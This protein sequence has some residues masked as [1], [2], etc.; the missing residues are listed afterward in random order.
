MDLGI[1]ANFVA[2]IS[3]PCRNLAEIIIS[4]SL[5]QFGYIKTCVCEL[6]AFQQRIIYMGETLCEGPAL[7]TEI[8]DLALRGVPCVS[9][10][11]RGF[12]RQHYNG[13]MH[14]ATQRVRANLRVCER[15]E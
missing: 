3:N 5:F 12:S 15:T 9:A 1:N 4:H 8:R 14:S 13:F 10:G 6:C 11:S 2:F 7:K